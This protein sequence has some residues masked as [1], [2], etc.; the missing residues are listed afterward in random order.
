MR[1]GPLRAH[2]AAN[3]ANFPEISSAN[4]AKFP[5]ILIAKIAIPVLVGTEI[6]QK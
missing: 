3:S 5:E 1:T 4:S 2:G 6:V